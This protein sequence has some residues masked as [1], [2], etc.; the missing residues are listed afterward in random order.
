[1]NDAARSPADNAVHRRRLTPWERAWAIGS[2]AVR[3]LGLAVVAFDRHA[4]ALMG[5]LGAT[6]LLLG[7][8]GFRLHQAALGLYSTWWDATYLSLQLFTMN[9]GAVSGA[10]EW[11]LQIG[12]FLAPLVTAGAAARALAVFFYE[13]FQDGVLRLF[14]HDHIVICGVG[15]KGTAL[16]EELRRRDHWVVV[17][18]SDPHLPGLDRCR[19]L[20]ATVLI[21]P[22]NDLWMLRRACVWRARALV[23]V[24][25]T[26]GANVETA[27]R[28]HE[29]NAR[30]THGTLR[31]VVHLV[32][33][34]LRGMLARTEMATRRGDPFEL[35]LFNVHEMC[36]RVMMDELATARTGDAFGD[37]PEH[38]LLVGFGEFGRSLLREAEAR[39]RA[40]ATSDDGFRIT[41]VDATPE[42]TV[43]SHVTAHLRAMD[44]C[45]V[46]VHHL[47]VHQPEFADGSF[48]DAA[49][50]GPVTA[51][52]VSLG[53]D[54]LGMYAALRL[55]EMLRGRDVPIFVRMSE[56]T[57]LAAALRDGRLEHG[58]VDGVRPIGLLEMTCRPDLVLGELI[59]AESSEP[60]PGPVRDD[61]P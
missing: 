26:D 55:Q 58:F 25:G 5:A 44:R 20:G 51:A 16:V 3:R 60:L 19:A 53:D 8:W 15:R 43:R 42:T 39:W 35:V 34:E 30:R 48:L 28:A 49:E 22:A 24:T 29:L 52:F 11:Q 14:G 45:T 54:S 10:V 17:I 7:I 31:C 46:T 6:A 23:A 37:R 41:I 4:W 40:R 38:L 12:R 33:R 13:Q 56:R 2:R 21:G 50:G 47:E 61:R 59:D 27:V 18:E 57:G 1:M 32:D 9:S 36:A